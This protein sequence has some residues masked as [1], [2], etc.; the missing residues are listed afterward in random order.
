MTDPIRW[1]IVGAS[2]FAR[3]SMGPALHA[4]RGSRVTALATRSSDKA[5]AFADFLPDLRIEEDY[6]AL[7][8]ADDIDAIYVPL[9]NHLHVEW[10]LKAL[11]A[12]K[13]VLCEKPIALHASEV[14]RLIAARDSSGLLAAE[15]FMIVHHPQWQRA[16]QLLSEG[17]VGRLR[18]V[19]TTF[20]F[21]NDDP[22]NIRNREGMGGGGLR[23]IGVY[24]FGSVLYATDARPGDMNAKLTMEGDWDSFAEVTAAFPDFTFHTVVS[25]RM[26][27]RQRVVFH[28]D[29]GVLELTAPFN[30][31]TFDQ[32][33]LVIETAMNT[34]T[35]E[36]WPGVNQYVLQVEAF[37]DSVRNGTPYA[38]TLEQTRGSLEM[39]DRSFEVGKG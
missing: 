10:V 14:D 8:R 39:I 11:E 29:K 7:L 2:N 24:A 1:G 22:A 27:P 37:C 5:A 16:R 30:A 31:G 34:R 26:A 18:H 9:P 13:H 33:E 6:D 32:A 17:T 35:I 19:E 28:G 38:W 23:D 12:G 25:T 20:T 15:A 3:K 36:R 4:A 21:F